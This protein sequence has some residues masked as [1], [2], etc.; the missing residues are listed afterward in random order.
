MHVD[1]S[2]TG[3]AWIVALHSATAPSKSFHDTQCMNSGCRAK[4][5]FP[6]SP[7]QRVPGLSLGP[8]PRG[9]DYGLKTDMRD[10]CI[11]A[12]YRRAVL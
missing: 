11:R 5:R 12:Y 2:A 10:K 6:L 1:G 4:K 7:H 9:G 3:R 8:D